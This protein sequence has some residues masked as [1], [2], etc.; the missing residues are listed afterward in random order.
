MNV[1][2]VTYAVLIA[3]DAEVG[4]GG[5]RGTISSADV[6]PVG[7][8]NAAGEGRYRCMGGEDTG[9][10]VCPCSCSCSCCFCL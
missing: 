2:G 5:P 3:D 6:I 4:V 9:E 10:E 8:D 1:E 7:D